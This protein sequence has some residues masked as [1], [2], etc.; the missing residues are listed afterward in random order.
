MK[1][2]IFLL[3]CV[4][5]ISCQKTPQNEESRHE[6]LERKIA[7][8]THANQLYAK[9]LPDEIY[10]PLIKN[11]AQENKFIIQFL[12]AYPDAYQVSSRLLER[13][14]A[15]N[16]E[17]SE[18]GIPEDTFLFIAE[19]HGRYRFRCFVPFYLSSDLNSVERSGKPHFDMHET[20]NIEQ[21][22]TGQNRIH[23]R[24]V[25][26]PDGTQRFELEHWIRLKESN[27]DWSA[28]G[29]ELR[30]DQPIDGFGDK[31]KI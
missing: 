13:A 31:N 5:L 3:L 14:G 11:L 21:P 4:S 2:H 28:L 10:T 9:A 24:A 25:K 17:L 6:M 27:F 30:T 1:K 26:L 16:L 12:E 20:Q 7:A 23:T 29:I 19:L 15:A 22:K 8:Y 18:G